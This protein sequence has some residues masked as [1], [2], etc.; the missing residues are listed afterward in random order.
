[1]KLLN[2]NK[3]YKFNE[4]D[5]EQIF[6]EDLDKIGVINYNEFISSMI[7]LKSEIRLEHIIEALKIFDSDKSGKICMKKLTQI[8]K[9]RTDTD[10]NELI[11][12]FDIDGDWEIEIKEFIYYVLE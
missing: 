5:L 8:I 9:P 4:E 10:L 2:K 6:N 7:K 3:W 11:K 12:K 1:M